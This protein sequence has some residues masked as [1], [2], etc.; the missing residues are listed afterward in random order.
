MHNNLFRHIAIVGKYG[1]SVA[2]TIER[3]MA[4]LTARNISYTLDKSTMPPELKNHPHAKFLGDWPKNI[5]LCIV[6]GGDG[7]FLHAGRATLTRQIPLLGINEGR[8]GF[9][10]DVQT[11]ELER[12]LNTILSG[13]Y[14]L[15]TR[16]T[17]LV[18]V[19]QGDKVRASYYAINDAVIHKRMMARM[20]ELDTY[21]N[22]S[23]LCHYRAD[24]LIL[25]TPTGSTAYALA[26]GGPILEPT[27]DAMI[28][29]PICPYMLTHR[30]MVVG[31]NSDI[32]VRLERNEHDIQLTIDGQEELILEARDYL[33]VKHAN[34]L[35]VI[36]PQ[37]YQFQRTLQE[38]LN[39]GLSP[40][41]IQGNQ[42]A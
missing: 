27:M 20:V 3:V 4:I 29:A 15:E 7:T 36:H 9:L 10:A 6:I 35:P 22:G 13:N 34:Q 2:H 23:F 24:G 26:A 19:R 11:E 25:S 31:P 30:P 42:H 5:D 32:E 8:L 17:L 14:F 21:T 12:E 41:Q 28:I 33:Y 16:Q 39:W 37:G 40:E 18:E 38:K 1:A